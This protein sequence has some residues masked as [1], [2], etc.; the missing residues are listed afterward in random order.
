MDAMLH[1][2]HFVDLNGARYRMPVINPRVS[3]F[4]VLASLAT[5]SRFFDLNMIVYLR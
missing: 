2:F 5:D 3:P 1:V 4:T